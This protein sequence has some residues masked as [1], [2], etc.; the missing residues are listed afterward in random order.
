MDNTNG[1]DAGKTTLHGGVAPNAYDGITDP[2][3]GSAS[4]QLKGMALRWSQSLIPQV[5]RDKPNWTVFELTWNAQKGK[6]DK[7][8]AKWKGRAKCGDP[9]TWR[10]WDDILYMCSVKTEKWNPEYDEQMVDGVKKS[11][12]PAYALSEDDGIFCIDLDHI[13]DAYGQCDPIAAVLL[14]KFKGTYCEQSKSGDGAHIF[15]YGKPELNGNV[16]VEIEGERLDIEV[17]SKDR[18]ICMTG[19]GIDSSKVK[20]ASND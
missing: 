6:Y 7:V 5:L 8:P 15:G 17:Y 14:D 10:T 20:E 4:R 13:Y 12:A 16:T 11:F 1:T 2:V 18:F 9:S 3:Y 19:I